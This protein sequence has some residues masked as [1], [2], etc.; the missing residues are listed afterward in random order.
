MTTRL[1]LASSEKYS[2]GCKLVGVGQDDNAGAFCCCPECKAL[3][4]KY[5]HPAG[6]Y[7]DFLLDMSARFGKS[8]PKL[9]IT[10][11]AYRDEQ[12]LFPAKC[13]KKL[14]ANL[15]PSFAPLMA[16]FA[17]PY[18]HAVNRKQFVNFKAWA[19]VASK[20]QWWSYPTT[21]PFPITSIPLGANIRRLADNFRT[22]HRNKVFDAYCQFGMGPYNAFGFNDLRLYMLCEL[23]RDITR[24]EQSIVVEYTDFCHG[25]AAPM[26]RKYLAELEELDAKMK[27]YL[28]WN[29]DL[30]SIPY[31][32]GKN[33]LRWERDFDTMEK[34][35]A[36]DPRRLFNVRRVRWT[37]DE[38]V[39]AKWPYL[40]PAEQ[41]AF[42]DL[43][44]YIKRVSETI[45][46]DHEELLSSI[47][48][49][50]P[51]RYKEVFA[52]RR[53]NYYRGL[54]QY[55][56]RARGGKDLPKRYAKRTVYRILP[57]RHRGGLDADPE[58]AFGL[59]NKG[60]YPKQGAWFTLR[61]FDAGKPGE[62]ESFQLPKFFGAKSVSRPSG[63]YGLHYL[64]DVTLSPD[65]QLSF[66]P[67]SRFSS[68]ALGHLYDPKRP[69][70]LYSLVVSLAV[71]PERKWVKLDQLLVFPTG[72][73]AAAGASGKAGKDKVD[74]FF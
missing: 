40:T 46:R 43:E 64:G 70:Q 37:L 59:C 11:L 50:D 67:I 57:N 34:L 68:F 19:K 47:R 14:P 55:I 29:P 3:E 13:M 16:D 66:S 60:A 36:D 7:Y 4:K 71:D 25:A 41:K 42:G 22:A 38:T 54:D 45:D 31:V 1:P 69:R 53:A 26:V 9:L 23:C 65:S 12:T 24:D 21:Y 2:G 15:L 73:D 32:T 48:E 30:L 5:G 33:L 28:R 8:H 35:V 72:R 49:S 27:F 39:I 20:M 63:K 62:W 10:F 17:K 74:A 52:R 6:A 51:A 58:A 44:T 56:A 61:R 18:T